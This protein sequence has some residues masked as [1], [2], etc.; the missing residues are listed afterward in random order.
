MPESF[1]VGIAQTQ[2]VTA[3]RYSAAAQRRAG[4]TLILGHGAGADQTSRF[5][6]AFAAA[7]AARG[8]DVVT[9][10][11]LYSELGRRVPDPSGRLEACYR[12]V[13]ETVRE[14]IASSSDKL[15]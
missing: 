5:I 1:R 14:R 12:T 10:N 9:F 15:A 13:I 4:V 2:L 11:F 8:I 6:V 7:L 3:T